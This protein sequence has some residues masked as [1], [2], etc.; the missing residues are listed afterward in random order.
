MFRFFV[1]FITL[2]LFSL[3]IKA[4]NVTIEADKINSFDNNSLITAEGSVLILYQD[5]VIST[6]K[7]T[8][9]K[10]EGY[11]ELEKDVV[12]KDRTNIIRAD[13]AK[14][15][16]D[17]RTGFFRY[18]KGFYAPWNYF[19]ADKLEKIGENSFILDNATITTCS[20]DNPDWSF[21]SSRAR[22]DVG[23]YFRSKH[24]F[25]NIKDVPIIYT[26]Y[27]VWPIKK[28]RQSGFLVPNFG[29]SSNRGFF[30]TPKYF[31]AIDVDKDMTLGVNLF[32]KNGVMFLDEFRYAVSKKENIHIIGEFIND[33]ESKSDKSDRWRLYGVG[34]KFF[35]D[36]LELKFNIDYVSDFRY[37]RDFS[38]YGIV[39]KLKDA[40]KDKNDFITELRLNYYTKNADFSLR[41]KDLMQFY[42][43][44]DGYTRSNLYQKP[45]FQIEKYGLKIGYLK[46][47]YLLDYN[48][49]EKKIYQYS[50][51]N[52]NK[53]ENFTYN[54]Y[55]ARIKIYKPFD[56][57]IA[58]LTP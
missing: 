48:D 35:T 30:I 3:E 13:Y 1:F 11:I 4:Q 20:G 26:P 56:I 23:Q 2:I 37:K 51:D 10:L 52:Q 8:Y 47:D 25:G 54:R 33:S 29:F 50:F 21:S 22:I 43:N 38:D 32:S 40:N 12:F 17:N 16:I 45:S 14:I 34:N 49:V 15:Y 39:D 7:A 9:N 36:N 46:A 55:N 57:K 18:G 41:Y 42:D 53:T 6:D 27:F 31:W 19:K 5:M 24:S 44:T 58:T 28:E